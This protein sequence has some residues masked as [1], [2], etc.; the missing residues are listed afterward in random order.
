MQVTVEIFNNE[1]LMLLKQLEQLQVLKLLS[2]PS[3]DSIV[4]YDVDG[5]PISDNE[6]IESVL[7]SSK[8]AQS[9][10][11]ISTSELLTSL[12]L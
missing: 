3:F 12:N 1:A 8:D 2:F 4:G 7:E 6:L 10:N 11:V 9:G 5:T